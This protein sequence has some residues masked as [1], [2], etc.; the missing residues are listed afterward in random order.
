MARMH[1]SPTTNNHRRG[2]RIKL[3]LALAAAALPFATGGGHAVA[4]PSAQDTQ[5][6]VAAHQSNLA[7]IAA[8]NSAQSHATLGAVKQLGAMFA[9]MHSQ[10]DAQ[11]TAAAATLGVALPSAPTPEQQQQLAAVEANSGTAYDTAW[12]A[13]QTAAH[14][15]TLAATRTEIASGSDP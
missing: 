8:G 15:Q 6:M 14:Q 4:A 2:R 9:Q 5:W 10:M 1:H 7:E 3:L 11:L 13:Q 12:I